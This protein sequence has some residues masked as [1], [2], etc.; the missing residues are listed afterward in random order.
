MQSLGQATGARGMAI[1][2]WGTYALLKALVMEIHMKTL[3]RVREFIQ[4]YRLYAKHHSPIYAARIAFGVAY[5]QLP[6]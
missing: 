5:R 4:V 6:F 1:T 3:K 2:P